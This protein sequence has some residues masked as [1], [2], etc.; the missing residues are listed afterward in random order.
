M[1]NYDCKQ[2]HLSQSDRFVIERMLMANQSFKDI[3]KKLG[4]HPATISREIRNNRDFILVHTAIG[5]DCALSGNC[6][7]KNLCDEDGCYKRCACCEKIV[8]RE[9]CDKYIPVHCS[10]LDKKPYVCNTCKKRSSCKQNHAYYNAH[11][12]N[13]NYLRN[14][15]SSRSGLRISADELHRI[16]EIIS[17]LLKQGQSLNHI[18]TSHKDDVPYSRKT[19]YNYIDAHAFTAKNIDLPRKVRYKKRHLNYH[20]TLTYKYREGRTYD[21]FKA[22][23]E[24]HPDTPVVEMDTVKGSREKG[25]VLLT[26][27][28]VKYSFL[29]IFLLPAPSQECVISIFDHLTKILG[30][31]LFQNL[32]PVILTDNGCEFK[33]VNALEYTKNGAAR[34]KVFYCDPMAS[35]QKPHIEKV[36]EFIRYVVP[37]GHPFDP[38]V[39][40]DL[41][42]LANHI[43]SYAR[44]SL[45][46]KCP[47]VAAKDFLGKKLLDSLELTYVSPDEVLLKPALLKH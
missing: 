37:K 39:Q 6:M 34:S 11:T 35:W 41:T 8:C 10:L 26:M 30:L 31:E 4:R 2:T 25:K 40:T 12:A 21:D 36:H 24:A 7:M 47:Y 13:A 44:D 45:N 32:F 28:F 17:P 20:S 29:L 18:M 27:I 23:M 14:L 1:D 43:N 22:Y 38:Y 3:A 16:D 19:I 42:L 33:N 15:S 46:G 9:C 5:N